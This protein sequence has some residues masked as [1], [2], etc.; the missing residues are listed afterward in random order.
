MIPRSEGV[1]ATYLFSMA[2]RVTSKLPKT[3]QSL[4]AEYTILKYSPSE[5]LHENLKK[6]EAV[7]VATSIRG[8]SVDRATMPIETG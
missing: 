8:H 5:V 1:A 4:S 7:H 3:I 2:G 6:L